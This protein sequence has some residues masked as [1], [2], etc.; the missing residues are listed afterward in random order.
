M[1]LA[2]ASGACSLWPLPSLGLLSGLVAMSSYVN[3]HDTWIG[4]IIGILGVGSFYVPCWFLENV[5]LIDEPLGAATLHMSL[6]I[7]GLI[8][9]SFFSN[10]PYVIHGQ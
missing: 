10:S 6:G 2:G 7:V 8:S 5:L 1:V 9:V 3:M 4:I